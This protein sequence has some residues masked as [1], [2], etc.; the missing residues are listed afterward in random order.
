MTA[1]VP[2][3]PFPKGQDGNDV[4]AGA[5]SPRQVAQKAKAHQQQAAALFEQGTVKAWY[6]S[7]GWTYPIQGT[8][9]VGKGAI[10][11]FF[12]VLGLSKPPPVEINTQHIE[13]RG[14]VGQQL[15]EHLSVS[16]KEAKFVNA[17]AQSDQAWIKVQRS[18]RKG[19]VV[20]IP[21]RIDIPACPGESLQGRVTVQGN[22]QQRF[23]VPVTLTIEAKTAKQREA[24]QKAK[25]LWVLAGVGGL[26]LLLT[27]GAG[28]LFLKSRRADP[29]VVDNGHPQQPQQPQTPK[30]EAW[31]DDNP[32]LKFAAEA[33]KLIAPA[34]SLAIF[35]RLTRK[36]DTDRFSAT[37]N[38]RRS[39]RNWYTTRRPGNH[40]LVS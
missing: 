26:V 7:N 10:Q 37:S 29:P 16:T 23:V 6:A 12:E 35:E 9:G 5:M 4:L 24:E 28:V 25:R 19:N 40:W 15:M 3:V 27:V 21:L 32:D 22:G 34:D 20:T 11:Q 38:W 36:V 39:C 18:I 33:V 1:L 13:C 14:E 17:E 30:G 31:W 2:I 8:Q